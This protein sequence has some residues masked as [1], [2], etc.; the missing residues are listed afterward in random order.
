MFRLIFVTTPGMTPELATIAT[1]PEAAAADDDAQA[2]HLD[3]DPPHADAIAAPRGAV[4][5]S[6]I[7]AR[8]DHHAVPVGGAIAGDAWPV[9]S[10]H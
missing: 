4:A 9:R 3:A 5:A 10:A 1:D 7:A 6:R 8:V 2:T